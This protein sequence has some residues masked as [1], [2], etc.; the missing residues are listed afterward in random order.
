MA[1]PE[2]SAKALA[3]APVAEVVAPIEQIPA[4]RP[5]VIDQLIAIGGAE[6]TAELFA[7]YVRDAAPQLEQAAVDLAAGQVAEL[8]API[9]QLKGASAQLGL[10]DIAELA[11]TLEQQVRLERPAAELVNDFRRLQTLF[12][13]FSEHYPRFLPPA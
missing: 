10:T 12:T 9:H 5:D 8:L 6:F 3:P 4:P 2:P 13:L 11:R 1:P 7:D